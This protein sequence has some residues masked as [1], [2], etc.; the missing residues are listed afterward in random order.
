MRAQIQGVH[1]IGGCG[2]TN[3]FLD[4]ETTG[5]NH[6]KNRTLVVA[7]VITDDH[8]EEI[9]NREY[10]ITCTNPDCIDP[11][12]LEVNG[13]DIAKHNKAANKEHEVV[14]KMNHEITEMLRKRKELVGD[15]FVRIIG[16]NVSFDMRFI[17]AMYVRNQTLR[18]WDGHI[19]DTKNLAQQ[20]TN[21][22][23]ITFRDHKLETVAARFAYPGTKFH[24]AMADVRATIFIYQRMK[25]YENM[26]AL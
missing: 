3:I 21:R 8:M 2:M 5:L 14:G 25:E 24:D 20:M 13:I 12:A 1:A 17:D 22:G 9:W 19:E 11:K 6:H 26:G 16:H 7:V 10:R 4:C 18:M 15:D 23:R